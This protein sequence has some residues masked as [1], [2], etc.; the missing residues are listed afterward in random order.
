MNVSVMIKLMTEQYSM[1]TRT[2]LTS[3][4]TSTH[5]A[6][7][8]LNHLII[9]Y[10]IPIHLL[11]DNRPQFCDY[12]FHNN[13]L[14]F[15][16]E[17]SDNNP[18]PSPDELKTRKIQQDYS[19]VLT[20]FRC[21]TPGYLGYTRPTADVGIQN[22]SLSLHRCVPTQFR[23]VKI[24]AWGDNTLSFVGNPFKRIWQRITLHIA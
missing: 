11:V 13:V 10:G 19:G 24:P 7:A 20:A 16:T 14:V 23:S 9:P 5:V 6:N 1:M 8:F 17:A 2:V 21:R 4:T 15:W 18:V 22:T 12:F 3:K